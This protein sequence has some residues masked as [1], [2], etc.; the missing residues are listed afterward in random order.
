MLPLREITKNERKINFST[1]FLVFEDKNN[2]FAFLI[3]MF[4]RIKTT[5][6]TKIFSRLRDSSFFLFC[7]HGTDLLYLFFVVCSK[8]HTRNIFQNFFAAAE[9][10]IIFCLLIISDSL[11]YIVIGSEAILL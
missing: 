11:I 2:V 6:H 7:F 3:L 4:L 5:I 8:Y 10:R 9:S 1:I